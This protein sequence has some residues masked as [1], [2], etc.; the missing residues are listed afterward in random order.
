MAT[1]SLPTGIDYRLVVSEVRQRGTLALHNNAID[2]YRFSPTRHHSLPHNNV[3]D[4]RKIYAV[5]QKDI[6]ASSSTGCLL[7]GGIFS[8]YASGARVSD[9]E[10]WPDDDRDL[11]RLGLIRVSGG[12]VG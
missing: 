2:A 6:S 1:D 5:E 10:E 11:V 9:E 7:S 8:R 12:D 4:G 3:T